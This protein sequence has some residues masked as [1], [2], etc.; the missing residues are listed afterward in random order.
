MRH[1]LRPTNTVDDLSVKPKLVPKMVSDVLLAC[2]PLLG[3]EMV[4]TGP[5][6]VKIET[7]DPTRLPMNPISEMLPLPR[8]G[9]HR[10]VVCVVH[11][12]VSHTVVPNRMLGLRSTTPRFIPLI[13]SD[14]DMDDGRLNLWT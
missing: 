9:M 14:N 4:D 12:M 3:K 1:A 5:S 10:S 6:Y 13:V 8:P 7:V 11:E 2:G